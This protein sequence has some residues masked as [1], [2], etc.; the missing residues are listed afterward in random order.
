[1]ESYRYPS[2]AIGLGLF[3][4]PQSSGKY[5]VDPYGAESPRRPSESHSEMFTSRLLVL[6]DARR[7]LQSDVSSSSP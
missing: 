3:L 2:R 5:Y 1:M 4:V 6:D 7:L